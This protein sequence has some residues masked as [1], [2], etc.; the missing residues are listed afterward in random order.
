MHDFLETEPALALGLASVLVIWLIGV[1]SDI[2]RRT[3]GRKPQTRSPWW[4]WVVTVVMLWSLALISVWTWSSSGRPVVTL[5]FELGQGWQNWVAW[6]LVI[7]FLAPQILQ[8]VAINRSDDMKAQVR[9]LVFESRDY[10]TVMPRRRADVW[11]YQIVAVTAGITEEIVFRAFLISV[12]ALWMPVWPAAGLALVLFLTAHAYQGVSGIVRI[13]PVSV[14]LTL[15]YVLSGSLW[16]V[17][18][19]HVAVDVLSGVMV[20]LVLPR[21]GMIELPD[22]APDAQPVG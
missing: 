1:G 22:R 3:R 5:G 2:W 17:I 19:L 16:P 21:A 12:F 7:G 6:A 11:G 13:L 14:V 18:V 8:L 9:A 20:W 4:H 10:D 15:C